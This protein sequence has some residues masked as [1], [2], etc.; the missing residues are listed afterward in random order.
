MTTPE[1]RV[2]EKVKA[3]LERLSIKCWYF[4]PVQRGLGC[5]K[6]VP[7]FIVC[8]QGLFL[9]IETKAGDGKPTTMQKFIHKRIELAGGGVIVVNENNVNDFEKVINEWIE[10]N[11]SA[12]ES[13]SIS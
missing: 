7:D 8:C 1:G 9:G 2:K 6:G 4:M 3:I 13:C 10:D 5:K 11:A 12:G